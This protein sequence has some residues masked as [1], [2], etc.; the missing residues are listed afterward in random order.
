MKLDKL[1]EAFADISVYG[2]FFLLSTIF[3]T[4][5]TLFRLLQGGERFEPL[6]TGLDKTAKK[7]SAVKK[8]R[9]DYFSAIAALKGVLSDIEGLRDRDGALRVALL[10]STREAC[11]N[12]QREAMLSA[13]KN[14]EPLVIG[15]EEYDEADETQYMATCA[16]NLDAAMKRIDKVS[17][18][19]FK[20]RTHR[21]KCA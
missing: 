10:A 3:S 14:D 2:A 19:P 13:K 18:R 21:H 16:K 12:R 9:A 1:L 15:K 5:P 8:S 17:A 7:E 20:A 6:F 4:A 11:S